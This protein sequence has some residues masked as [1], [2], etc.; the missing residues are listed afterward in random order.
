MS[1]LFESIKVEKRKFVNI[2]FHNERFNRSR[3][4]L[5]NIWEEENLEFIVTIP[6]EL[7]DEIYKCRIF[8]D[9]KIDKVE[10]LK[11]EPRNVLS[12]KTVTCDD[13]FYEYKYADRSKIDELKDKHASFPE[14]D[15]LVVKNGLITDTSYSNIVFF[16]GGKW[17]TPKE[18]LLS[19]TKR[20]KLLR[21]GR[22]FDRKIKLTD[23]KNYTEFKMINAMMEFDNSPSL[24]IDK[25]IYANLVR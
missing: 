24:Q 22:I 25:I 11:Y 9:Y 5:L 18:P 10:F 1:L 2:S 15:I 14:E 6:E 20:E 4:K 12:L 23:L 21:E 16:D 3:R 19:G 17:F 7:N 13:I 8:Y